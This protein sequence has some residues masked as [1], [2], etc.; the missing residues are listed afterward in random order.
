MKRRAGLF[1][2]EEVRCSVARLFVGEALDCSTSPTLEF[3]NEIVSTSVKFPQSID[4]VRNKSVENLCFFPTRLWS[5][6]F[7]ERTKLGG[8]RDC[9]L[10]KVRK[11]IC[12]PAQVQ[13][14]LCPCVCVSATARVSLCVRVRVC[15]CVRLCLAASM[16]N[17]NGRHTFML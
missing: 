7:L 3:I 10:G 4:S 12:E 9:T 16:P 2:M 11:H 14:P 17:F 15:L 8:T 5:L 6:V 13:L 1:R